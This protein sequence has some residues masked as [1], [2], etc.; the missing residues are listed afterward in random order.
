MADNEQKFEIQKIFVKDISFEAPNSPQVFRD[1][2][3][4]KTEVHLATN[5]RK[6]DDNMFEV[7]LNI[8]VTAKQEEEQAKIRRQ[9]EGMKNFTVFSSSSSSSSSSPSFLLLHSTNLFSFYPI[10]PKC[11]NR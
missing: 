5:A 7:I 4:P 10:Y 11:F 9:Q 2:W 1:K 8:T 3:K 6:L